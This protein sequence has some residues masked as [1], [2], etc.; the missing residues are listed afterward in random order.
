MMYKLSNS[1]VRMRNR[2]TRAIDL[3]SMQENP[4]KGRTNGDTQGTESDPCPLSPGDD[5]IHNDLRRDSLHVREESGQ[6][7]EIAGHSA[8]QPGDDSEG[9]LQT[10]GDGEGSDKGHSGA[11][12]QVPPHDRLLQ[13]TA[14]GTE[15]GDRIQ[16]ESVGCV[17]EEE[18]LEDADDRSDPIIHMVSAGRGGRSIG[19]RFDAAQ[20][21]FLEQM[22][23]KDSGVYA[24]LSDATGP[25]IVS[26]D[27]WEDARKDPKIKEFLDEA[28]AEWGPM[29]DEGLRQHRKD[30]K[31]PNTARQTCS[32]GASIDFTSDDQIE[33]DGLFDEFDAKH[34]ECRDKECTYVPMENIDIIKE[35]ARTVVV[36]ELLE[37]IRLMYSMQRPSSSWSDAVRHM[38][39]WIDDYNRRDA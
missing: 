31:M 19:L 10:G 20:K 7:E 35:S 12:T 5:R 2:I 23:A 21:R 9:N 22:G 36:S 33:L 16:S 38:W 34:A 13:D 3:I 24:M 17:Q 37:Q 25:T 15:E 29:V 6:R 18:V 27:E 14:G 32:C 8:S 30:K 39:K 28:E 26:Y 4:A 11:R 1:F